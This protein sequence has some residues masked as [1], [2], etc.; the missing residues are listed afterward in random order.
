MLLGWGLTLAAL[1]MAAR[2]LAAEGS[3]ENANGAVDLVFIGAEPDWSLV[4]SSIG[5]GDFRGTAPR[6][7]RAEVFD[8]TQILGTEAD[9]SVRVRCWIDLSDPT[10]A[11]LYF[12]NRT[13]E[14]FLVRELSLPS[15]LDPLGR[16]ALSQVIQLSVLA[17]LEDEQAGITREEATRL[18]SPEAPP[19]PPPA[20]PPEAPPA[21]V[22][23]RAS[24][25]GVAPFYSAKL[26]ASEALV[27][28][29]PGIALGWVET[30]VR[31]HLA[32]FASARYEA[33]EEVSFDRVGMRWRSTAV[34]VDL[35]L[36]QALSS[37]ALR[38]G[39]KLGAGVDLVSVE[40]QPS[41]DEVSLEPERRVT[42]W[43]IDA[44]LT[45]GVALGSRLTLDLELFLELYPRRV[46]YD[47]AEGGETSPVFSPWRAQPG[48]R[49]GVL[50][51]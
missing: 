21:P 29:G 20:P 15:G 51:Y 49:I 48:L 30:S 39:G 8:K 38:A 3:S 25:L 13:A 42:I 46:H 35:A 41:D 17:L 24:G 10:T 36:L 16:E 12:A 45:A 43:A 2:A 18:L 31:S 14:R 5:P 40:P 47:L 1:S 26:Q 27:V 23:S 7:R 32:V 44:G 34:R 50:F 11:H 33:Q 6:W 22:S 28:H 9:A 37:G 4:Q 19:A